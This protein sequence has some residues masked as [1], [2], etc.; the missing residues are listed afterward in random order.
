MTE[1]IIRLE[2]AKKV[3]PGRPDRATIYRWALGDGSAGVRLETVK[4]GRKRFTSKQAIQRFVEASTAAA[5]G[6][7]TPPP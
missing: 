7:E 4:V 6:R 3:I 5:G 1:D 2:D